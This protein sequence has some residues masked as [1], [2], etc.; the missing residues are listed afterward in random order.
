MD[1]KFKCKLVCFFGV[2]MM[3]DNKVLKEFY[4]GI[5]GKI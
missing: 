4:S 2:L 3:D 5:E 1:D